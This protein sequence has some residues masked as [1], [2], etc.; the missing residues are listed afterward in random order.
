MGMAA[1]LINEPW[2]IEQIFNSPLTEGSTWSL[3]KIGLRVSEEKLFKGVDR[4]NNDRRMDEGWT[5]SD[6]N[7][8]SWAFSSGELK[9]PGKIA[10]FF[11]KLKLVFIYSLTWKFHLYIISWTL[12]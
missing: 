5:A 9:R 12:S 10:S 2:P 1:I 11:E 6:H 8:S 7:S 4:Q 3:K